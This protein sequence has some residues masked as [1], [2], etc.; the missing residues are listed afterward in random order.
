MT[1]VDLVVEDILAY[2]KQP[3]S[4]KS[5]FG[6]HI[7]VASSSGSFSSP[8]M[9]SPSSMLPT[10]SPFTSFN[11]GIPASKLRKSLSPV[12]EQDQQ[13]QP[14]EQQQPQ[15]QLPVTTSR[16]HQSQKDYLD[17]ALDALK[18]IRNTNQFMLMTINRCIDFSKASNGLKLI[19]KLESADLKE[20]LELPLLCMTNI[21]NRISI[22]LLPFQSEEGGNPLKKEDICSHIITDRQWLQE[23]ILCLLSNA[24]KYSSKGTVTISVK[25]KNGREESPLFIDNSNH[26]NNQIW[27]ESQQQQLD[28]TKHPRIT[29][30]SRRFS[31]LFFSTATLQSANSS[32]GPTNS[33][34]E[35]PHHLLSRPFRSIPVRKSVSSVTAG[36]QV[37]KI[38][39][40]V[41]HTD[42]DG[43]TDVSTEA[44]PL[45]A[46]KQ[47]YLLFEVSDEGI[48]MSES[49]MRTLFSPFRQNQRLAGGTGLGLYSLAKRI[50]TLKG[51]YGV[52][53]RDDGKQGSCFYFTF[54]YRPDIT[55]KEQ[56]QLSSFQSQVSCKFRGNLIRNPSSS[57]N[58]STKRMVS[59]RK[60]YD[61]ETANITIAKQKVFHILL[62]EDTPSIAKMTSL[63]LKR[64]GHKVTLAENGEIGLNKMIE[65]YEE[66]KK[67]QQEQKLAQQEQG[68]EVAVRSVEVDKFDVVL[69]D[70]QMPVMDGLESTKRLRQY[71]SNLRAEKTAFSSPVSSEDS[72]NDD[73]AEVNQASYHQLI[74]GVTAASDEETYEEGIKVGIDDF[75]PKPF[76]SCMF[77]N[78]LMKLK[79]S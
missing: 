38:Y 44:V 53:K 21:Q 69:M 14:D 41:K 71:E 46:E 59:L 39:P 5:S 74:I 50:E 43:M 8:I 26:N 3:N 13:P 68:G 28:S 67:Q 36:K 24:V 31:T 17:D 23:N 15:Q 7:T 79:T 40:S 65:K 1:G 19:P 27:R 70:L 55:M 52:R 51:T 77:V 2:R 30:I 16:Q 62:V 6:G 32:L 20:M 11:A 29:S 63:M 47:Q 73:D 72:D 42:T 25:L 75:L 60:I 61:N 4:R 57:L 18:N 35:S 33:V 9:P 22:E 45:V 54:P 37:S 78:I 64:M 10:S 34:H 12:A 49:S 56:Q 58:G 66:A 76:T 48:G